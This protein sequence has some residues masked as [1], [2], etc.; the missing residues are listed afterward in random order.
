[1]DVMSYFLPLDPHPVGR[2]GA[3]RGG[4]DCV[5][6]P[7]AGAPAGGS[8]CPQAGPPG[9]PEAGPGAPVWASRRLPLPGAGEDGLEAGSR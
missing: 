1:M 4:G 9:G 6:R 7:G 3:Q 5:R 2:S 8:H